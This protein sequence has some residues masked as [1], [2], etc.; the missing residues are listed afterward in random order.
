MNEPKTRS[1]NLVLLLRV[2]EI[3]LIPLVIALLGYLGRSY[4]LEREAR[5]ANTQLYTELTINREAADSA[6]RS[7]MFNTIISTFL[8]PD[9][10]ERTDRQT[11]LAVELLAQNFNEVI[12][13]SPLFKDVR[14]HVSPV[15][16]SPE[17][18]ACMNAETKTEQK[19]CL[20]G[21]KN[22]EAEECFGVEGMLFECLNDKLK[23]ETTG[24]LL[25]KKRKAMERAALKE[26]LEQVAKQV[27]A[28]QT[29]SLEAVSIIKRGGGNLNKLTNKKVNSI[30]VIKE[31]LSDPKLDLPPLGFRLD[32][33]QYSLERQ[34]VNVRLMVYTDDSLKGK[35]AFIKQFWVG[36]FDFPMIDNIRLPGGQRCAVM[37]LNLTEAHTKLALL[38]FP[39]SRASL[40]ERLYYDEVIENL[41][42]QNESLVD[43]V[44]D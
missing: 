32:V 19:S 42:K 8:N 33:L 40:K 30:N 11:V 29:G 20:D 37:L 4:L 5:E 21:I 10:K 9:G 31:S 15:E 44:S 28:N 13:L 22:K 16:L 25:A 14:R 7:A 12:D 39:G 41:N 23:K 35:P 1:E 26:R 38:Y 24:D 36:Y 17:I 6:L 3:L 34:E 2:L 27:A 43:G 18:R